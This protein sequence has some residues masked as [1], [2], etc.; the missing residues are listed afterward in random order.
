MKLKLTV[1]GIDCPNCAAK[2]A[3]EIEGKE[4]VESCKINFLSE[5]LTLETSLAESDAIALVERECRA[6]SKDVKV[7]K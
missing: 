3:A 1:T 6:F 5:R 7:E 4:G 2:L